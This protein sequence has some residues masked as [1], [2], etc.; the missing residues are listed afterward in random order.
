MLLTPVMSFT[1]VVWPMPLLWLHV[2][3][4]AHTLTSGLIDSADEDAARHSD[5]A[6]N[7]STTST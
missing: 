1:L 7:R 6:P 5:S 3:H 2:S 4:E